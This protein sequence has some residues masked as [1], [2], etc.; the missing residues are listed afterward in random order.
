MRKVFL[1]TAFNNWGKSTL[2]SDLFGMKA[3][4]KD[5]PHFYAGHPFLVLTKS[6]D[7]LGKRGYERE[8]REGLRDFQ[9]ANGAPSYIASAFCPTREPRNDSKEILRSL[10]GKDKIEMLLLEYKWCGHA[11]LLLREIEQ[12]YAGEKNVTI[13]RVPSKN[14]AGKLTSVKAIISF[15]L[16]S[17]RVGRKATIRSS[18]RS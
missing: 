16:P 4:R 14:R 9:K 2:L 12:F 5:V 7:D 17:T 3:F 1:I 11:K 8:Y 6:N 18:G 15:A 13:H 10:Y